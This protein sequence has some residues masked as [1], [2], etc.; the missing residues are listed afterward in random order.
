MIL[1]IIV[2]QKGNPY[3]RPKMVLESTTQILYILSH[4]LSLG[5]GGM[6]GI[7]WYLSNKYYFS[8]F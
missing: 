6:I 5:S 1:I 2:A 3:Y 4:V 7:V 8:P